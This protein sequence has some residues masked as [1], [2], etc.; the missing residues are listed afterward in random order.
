M[1]KF[2]CLFHARNF[3]KHHRYG[4]Y[5]RLGGAMALWPPRSA[6]VTLFSVLFK[7]PLSGHVSQAGKFVFCAR[8]I[9]FTVRFARLEKLPLHRLLI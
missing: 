6:A 9:F 3:K 5:H 8:K 7:A 2:Y 4:K 1:A